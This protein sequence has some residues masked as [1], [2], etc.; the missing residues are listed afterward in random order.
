MNAMI[1]V[2]ISTMA[3]HNRHKPTFLPNVEEKQHNSL[4]DAKK[5]RMFP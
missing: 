3:H 2:R 4:P 5:G 1:A